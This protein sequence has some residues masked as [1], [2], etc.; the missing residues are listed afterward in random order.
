MPDW[1]LVNRSHVLKAM[2]EY[3][4]LGDR[5]FLR[6]YGFR[7]SVAYTVWHSGREY[8][9][10]A[11]LG[12]AYMYATGTPA[13]SSEF[14]GGMDGAAKVLEDRGF[15]VV[16]D[17]QEVAAERPRKVAPARARTA[18]AAPA[19]KVCPTCHLA[20]PASG[21]CDYCD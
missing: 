5:E 17:E 13:M 12:V 19:V 18:V 3:D 6:R 11:I 2:G 20:V 8:D 14:S 16:V 9:S 7:R 10:K 4:S 21:V 1:D 15:D